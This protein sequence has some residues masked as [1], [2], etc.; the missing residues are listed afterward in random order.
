MPHSRRLNPATG[1]VFKH[2]FIREDGMIFDGY[3]T[4]VLRKKTGFCKEVWRTPEG[5]EESLKY[6]KRRKKFLYNMIKEIVNNEKSSRGCQK[7]GYNKSCVGFP[8]Y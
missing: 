5:Y 1:K 2:G 7:C 4:S 8:P 3:Q 6:D